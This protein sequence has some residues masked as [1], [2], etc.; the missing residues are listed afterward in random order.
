M[1]R[2][3]KQPV[4]LGK[5][6]LA[7]ALEE[8]KPVK[9]MVGYI[10]VEDHHWDNGEQPVFVKVRCLGLDTKEDGCGLTVKCEIFAGAGTISITPCRWIDTPK[11]MEDLYDIKKRQAK[12]EED[13]AA[14]WER[15]HYHKD[16]ATFLDNYVYA[17]LTGEALAG[18]KDHWDKMAEDAGGKKKPT[19]TEHFTRSALRNLCK[20]AVLVVN[21]LNATQSPHFN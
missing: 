6:S 17:N 5:S 12:A 10:E 2:R 21:Q 18:W 4:P 8:G 16:K 7:T 19:K 20:V 15:P 1:A 13:F 11:Q 9:G 3:R 14:I